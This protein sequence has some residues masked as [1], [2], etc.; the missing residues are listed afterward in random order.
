MRA[1]RVGKRDGHMN[2]LIK[3]ADLVAFDLLP[4]Q[5]VGSAPWRNL[6]INGD[7]FDVLRYLHMA[8]AGKVRRIL[9]VVYQ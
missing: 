7:N 8:F 5:C 9:E 1:Y 3:I 4:K 6:I 2:A